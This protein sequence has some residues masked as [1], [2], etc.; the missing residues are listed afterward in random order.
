MINITLEV[1]V[2]N[3][4]FNYNWTKKSKIKTIIEWDVGDRGIVIKC[5]KEGLLSL[6]NHLV[7]LSQAEVPE[8]YHIHLDEF[9]SLESGSISLIIEKSENP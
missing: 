9:N 5:N 2:F 1:P 7:N 8:H 3:G 4:A 6:A